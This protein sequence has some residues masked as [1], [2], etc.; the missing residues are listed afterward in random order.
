MNGFGHSLRLIPINRL[1]TTCSHRTEAAA[2]CTDISKDHECG[3]AC[4]PAFAHI[5]AVAAFTNGM[6]LMCIDKGFL[7]V[8][9][10]RQW[11]VLHEANLVSFAVVQILLEV[12]SLFVLNRITGGKRV[13]RNGSLIVAT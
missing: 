10:L 5:G 2:S 4:A 13:R 6:K 8:Y 11:E 7:H 3:S 1:R 12:L 9:I